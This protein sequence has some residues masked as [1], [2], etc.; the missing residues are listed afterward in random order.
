MI[1][2]AISDCDLVIVLIGRNWL[3]ILRQR[4]ANRER[5][6]VVREIRA[7]LKMDKEIVP[8]LVDGATMPLPMPQ[9]LKSLSL[10]ALPPEECHVCTGWARAGNSPMPSARL[11]SI[12]FAQSIPTW[13]D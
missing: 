10:L 11:S 6:M 1:H 12:I 5:D 2:R 7:A 3:D 4:M 13:L 9:Q 8:L